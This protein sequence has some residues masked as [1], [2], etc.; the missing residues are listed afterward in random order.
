MVYLDTNILVYLFEHHPTYGRCVA[1]TITELHV[2][3]TFN[4]ATLTVTEGL[5]QV[6]KI[7]LETFLAMPDL[8]L[9]PLDATIAARAGKLQHDTGLKIG[10]AI[11][12][13]TAL[14]RQA[15]VFLTNDKRLAKT[16]A[17]Y[18]SVKTLEQA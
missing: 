5:A 4:C 8:Q 10:D 12:L 1:E 15:D 13:A 11:H 9:V 7:T 3:H 2:D 6:T 16:A 18:L 14:D 17:Q